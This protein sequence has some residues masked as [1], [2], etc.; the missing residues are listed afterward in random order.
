M[1]PFAPDSSSYDDFAEQ[2]FLQVVVPEYRLSDA[3]RV[4]PAG[5][6]AARR[7]GGE[8][9]LG[10]ALAGE[11]SREERRNRADAGRDRRDRG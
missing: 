5:D 7:R 2:W 9:R 8:R 11:R 3:K 6:P 1:R 4:E 10:S